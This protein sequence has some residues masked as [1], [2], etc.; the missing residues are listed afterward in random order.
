MRLLLTR[1][2]LVAVI[3]LMC[4]CT[5]ALCTNTH[6][7]Q[8]SLRE[9]Q[10]EL[11]KVKKRI[12][13][14]KKAIRK[15][16]T[17]QSKVQKTLEKTEVS[18]GKINKKLKKVSRNL[19]KSENKIREL[20]LENKALQLAKA[21]QQVALAE[22]LRVSYTQRRQEHIKLLLNLQQPEKFS[23]MMRYFDY[24][25]QARA[26]RIAGFKATLQKIDDIATNM[27]AEALKLERLGAALNKQQMQLK[28]T[29]KERKKALTTVNSTL[30]TKD[31]KLNQL[32]T[33]QLQLEDLLTRVQKALDDL[34]AY[35]GKTTFYSRKGKLKW[36]TKGRL[37]H[38][39]GS[40]RAWG[41][42]K[43][44][45]IVIRARAGNPVKAVHHGR[46]VFSDWLIGFGLLTIIDHGG[47]Y[48]SLYGHNES[49][50]KESGEWVEAGDILAT[51]G[52]SGGRDEYGLYF[53]IRRKGKPTNPTR[54]MAKK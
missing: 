10:E 11:S 39:F 51:V 52:N 20:K 21:S 2:Q 16:Y 7:K 53:E 38:R 46:V 47:G 45:G 8:P 26:Q 6:A 48:M 42:L 50:L 9:T 32:K 49:L 22:D 37:S 25:H 41:K 13:A 28:D 19:K 24:F 43:W 30:K 15:Q 18:I 44:Q 40:R 33:N 23:R 31:A 54:W 12:D 34:P 17:K 4:L 1:I 29:R 14:V 36:P 27:E 5:L 35:V 3:L